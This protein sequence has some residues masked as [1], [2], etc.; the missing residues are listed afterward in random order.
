MSRALVLLL[1]SG[2]M[3]SGYGR[4]D[5]GAAFVQ[6]LEGIAG[7]A[8]VAAAASPHTGTPEEPKPPPHL[9]GPITGAVL[10]QGAPDDGIPGVTLVMTGA[11][12]GTSITTTTGVHGRFELPYP[13]PADDYRIEIQ[14]AALRGRLDIT[15]GPRG[16]LQ[17]LVV[18]ARER[19]PSSR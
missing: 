7:I 1:V 15:V 5:D 2:C 10:W 9:R 14:N 12:G 3:T 4:G 6:A 11:S 8:V 16:P 18:V 17:D 13:I 19:R